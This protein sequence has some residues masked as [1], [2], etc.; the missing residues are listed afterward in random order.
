MIKKQTHPPPRRGGPPWPLKA[1]LGLVVAVLFLGVLEIGFRVLLPLPGAKIVHPPAKVPQTLRIVVAGGSTAE[2]FPVPVYGFAAQLEAAARH[3]APQQPIEIL[4]L[5]ASGQASP[6]VRRVLERYLESAAP[7]VV[8]VLCG[9]NEYLDRSGEDLPVPALGDT[10]R[11]SGL[12]RAARE[13]SHAIRRRTAS[14]H[15]M[16]ETIKPYDHGSPWFTH[17]LDRF[18]LNLNAMADAAAAR[19][20]PFILC[21]AP[22]NLA[23]WAPV[24]R[25]LRSDP[26]DPERDREAAALHDAVAAG[27]WTD[28]GA[29]AQSL[30]DRDAD[31]AYAAYATGRV[32]QAQSD[33]DDASTWLLRARDLDPI[34]W[35]SGTAINDAIRAAAADSPDVILADLVEAFAEHSPNRLPGFDLFDDNCHPT[36]LGNAVIALS[37]LDRL[38]ET[39][40]LKPATPAP[41]DP[42]AWLEVYRASLGPEYVAALDARR[43]LRSGMYC[44]KHPFLAFEASERHLQTALQASPGMWETWGNLGALRLLE[45]QWEEGRE[46]LDQAETLRGRPLE[47]SDIS[48]IPYLAE[49]LR[50]AEENPVP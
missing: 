3:V 18:R 36:P 31:H 20:V 14:S 25:G 22:S 35:R 30:T 27:A 49:A 17:I 28:A 34:P 37:L 44:M 9:H 5:G 7:D 26:A 38:I 1:L 12:A 32:L 23:D 2:G 47:P 29:L 8:I 24:W 40:L 21:T 42:A 48:T 45:S 19:R 39:G 6:Y 15:A 33:F 13:V 10:L 46:L 4:N 41:R 11:Q 43:H 50:R 16:P